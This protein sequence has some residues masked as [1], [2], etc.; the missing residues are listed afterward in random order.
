[1]LENYY[2]SKKIEATRK[3]GFRN[4][5]FLNPVFTAFNRLETRNVRIPA[6]PW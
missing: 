5:L 2:E 4:P 1:M 3:Y 6:L